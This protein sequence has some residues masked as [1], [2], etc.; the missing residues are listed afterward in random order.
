MRR[1]PARLLG[2]ASVAALSLLPTATATSA[3]ASAD[4]DL[5]RS[6]GPRGTKVT[7]KGSH[8]PRDRAVSL[9]Y[10]GKRVATIKTN[11]RGRFSETF[12]IP[13]NARRGSFR[14]MASAGHA[15]R[16]S[17]SFRVTASATNTAAAAV[18]LS[19]T[20]GP[21][22]TKVTVRG[23]NFQRSYA[24][25]IKF[26][27]VK[28]A[29]VRTDSY[30]RFTGT[31]TVASTAT[32]GSGTVLASVGSYP[33]Q[34]S[35]TFLVTSTTVAPSPTPTATSTPAPTPTPVATPSP[36]PA[37]TATPTPIATPAPTPVPINGASTTLTS[38]R[39]GF[40]S[41]N[42]SSW[43]SL[44]EEQSYLRDLD[45]ASDRVSVS[46]I[47]RSVNGRPIQ[48]IRVG[49]PRTKA[50]IASGS[51]ILFTCTQH[52]S[53]PAGREA[54]LA[55]ARDYANTP[56][57]STLLIVPTAN[58]DGFATSSRFNANGVDINRDHSRLA[59]PEARALASVTRDY[60]PDVVGDMHEYQQAGA[61]EVKYANPSRLH[62]NTDAKI[63]DATTTLTNS[64]FMPALKAAGFST[65]IYSSSGESDEI[66]HVVMRQQAALRHS[67]TML[68]ET[69]RLGTLSQTQRVKAQ[70][71]AVGAMMKMVLEQ[72]NELAATTNGAAQRAIAEG[73]A[74]NQRYYY[75]SPLTYSDTPPCAYKLTDAQYQSTQR[76]LGLHGIAATSSNGS[77]MVS[78]AQAAQ[79]VIGLL[80]DAR[81][82]GEMTAGQR[83]PC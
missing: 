55:G 8:F 20:S 18:T 31:F 36:T 16:A 21:R 25:W 1:P 19:P 76:T 62:A 58:P 40:E 35:K 37:P 78:T 3:A 75:T 57:A 27:G 38:L 53:E 56:N 41:R 64:Y 68:V 46:E 81:S 43:T 22:G 26:R 79:P 77:W 51:S 54:C 82:D 69:P 9:K 32:I 7:V 52:G 33:S 6:S 29:T 14:V 65:G 50:E 34:A 70:R 74:G 12:A 5:S 17:A 66:G 48:L 28:V 23:T 63:V 83:I 4:I 45:A 47:G 42:G 11:R 10:G 72:T 44:S 67:A 71:A 59:T 13:A 39:T 80:L 2:V 24:G 30:G 61:S 49:A 73:A 60:K 15:G